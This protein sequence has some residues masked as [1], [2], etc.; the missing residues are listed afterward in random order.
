MDQML[1]AILGEVS[2]CHALKAAQ[3]WSLKSI[4]VLIVE[5]KI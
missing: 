2:E 3:R 1:V 4:D 5:W